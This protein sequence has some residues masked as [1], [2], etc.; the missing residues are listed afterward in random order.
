MSTSIETFPT[1]R[2]ACKY[3]VYAT[4]QSKSMKAARNYLLK[5]IRT[6][7][8]AYG[9]KP[10]RFEDGSVSLIKVIV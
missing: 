2:H 4:R 8:R 9:F 5:A 10:V 6:D 7:S 3:I 1:L